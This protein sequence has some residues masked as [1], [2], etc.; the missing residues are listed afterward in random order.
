MF[1]AQP[2][3]FYTPDSYMNLGK[4]ILVSILDVFEKNPYSRVDN[5]EF[6]SMEDMRKSLATEI[7]Q[8]C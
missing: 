3:R 5:S 6:K 2:N 4:A 1:E 7:Y 8:G